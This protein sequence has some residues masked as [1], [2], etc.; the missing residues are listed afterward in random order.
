[1]GKAIV[2]FLG[3]AAV[4]VLLALAWRDYR[5]PDVEIAKAQAA[6]AEA[7]ARVAEANSAIERQEEFLKFMSGPTATV[8]TLASVCVGGGLV[9][10]VAAVVVMFTRALGQ[11]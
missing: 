8:L 7:Q 9:M 1:M 2:L 3:T 10:L 6:V 11:Q 5:L 4:I